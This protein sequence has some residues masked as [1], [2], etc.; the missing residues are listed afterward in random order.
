MADWA[1]RIRWLEVARMY[2][3][4]GTLVASAPVELAPSLFLR[5]GIFGHLSC[6]SGRCATPEGFRDKSRACIPPGTFRPYLL[7]NIDRVRL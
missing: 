4:G 1:N 6:R 3:R 2:Q 5:G 7:Y